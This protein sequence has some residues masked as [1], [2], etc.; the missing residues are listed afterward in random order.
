MAEIKDLSVTDAS[1]TARWPE[2]MPPSQVNDAGRADEGMLARAFKDSIDGILITGGTGSAYTATAN[3]SFTASATMYNGAE[4][5]L[6]FH[7]ACADTPTLNVSTTDA[8]KIFW[9]DG[10]TLSASD[11]LANTQG[12]VKY[13]SSLSA[14]V[15]M[16]APVPS[17]NNLAAIIGGRSL[18]ATVTG[19]AFV[20]V[21]SKATGE[22]HKMLRSNIAPVANQAQMEAQTAGAIPDAAVQHF[23]P[24]AT[25]AWGHVTYSTNVPTLRASYNVTSITDTGTGVLDVT[26]ATDFS[27]QYYALTL[28]ITQNSPTTRNVSGV[29]S[30]IAGSFTITT[31]TAGGGSADN[32]ALSFICCGDL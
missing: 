26:I 10:T 7:A 23:H 9:P 17:K 1:N 15:L 20:P 25:K 14:W 19:T 8:R 16:D 12:R 2:N 6:R 32:D 22:P 3:R 4:M 11:I 5:F 24:S 21:L 28:G 31:G 18:T 30:Q 13:N 27:G 29:Q